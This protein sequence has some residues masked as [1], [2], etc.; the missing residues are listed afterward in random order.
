MHTGEP[1]KKLVVTLSGIS[2]VFIP[3]CKVLDRHLL[4]GNP[5]FYELV[6]LW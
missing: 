1:N 3:L 5:S 4:T 6:T 2:L